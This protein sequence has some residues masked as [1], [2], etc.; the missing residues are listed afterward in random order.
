MKLTI[1]FLLSGA[2]QQ[3]G[4]NSQS[5]IALDVH[6]NELRLSSTAQGAVV[7]KEKHPNKQ[8]QQSVKPN[9]PNSQNTINMD[10]FHCVICGSKTYMHMYMIACMKPRNTSLCCA[11][12]NLVF[13]NEQQVLEHGHI[14]QIK[15]KYRIEPK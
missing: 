14:V 5:L 1:Y 7:N 2:Q 15:S 6:L 12:C 13:D 10:G 8:N 3:G 9:E 11:H 4:A